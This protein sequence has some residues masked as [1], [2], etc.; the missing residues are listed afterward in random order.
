MPDRAVEGEGFPDPGRVTGAATYREIVGEVAGDEEAGPKEHG[1]EEDDDSH[2]PGQDP[3]E[4]VSPEHEGNLGPPD[5]LFP[6]PAN[7]VSRFSS[8]ERSDVRGSGPKGREGLGEVP[9][10]ATEGVEAE[11]G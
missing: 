10:K 1:R 4:D 8:Q 5:L 7:E 11:G 3:G 9:P 6:P 2:D